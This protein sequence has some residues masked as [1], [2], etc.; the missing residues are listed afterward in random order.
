MKSLITTLTIILSLNSFSFEY[1]NS[2]LCQ[3][4]ESDKLQTLSVKQIKSG[5]SFTEFEKKAVM[6]MIKEMYIYGLEDVK[7]FEDVVKHFEESPW[8]EAHIMRQLDPTTGNTYTYVWSY[9]GDNEYGVWLDS[10]IEIFGE[11]QDGD[12]LI[13]DKYCPWEE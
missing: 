5:V 9:P 8:E 13:G 2:P 3:L 7:T 6:V 12:L 4:L 11:I 1:S 10:N